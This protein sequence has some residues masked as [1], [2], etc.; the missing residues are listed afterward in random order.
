MP[1]KPISTDRQVNA[2]KPAATQYD[3]SISGDR[4]LC[5][6]VYTSGA[7][8]FQF[9]YTAR[10]GARRR[11]VMG[12]YPDLSLAA[13]RIKAAGLR[14]E[15]LEGG[16]PAGD[17][18]AEKERARTGETL[19]DL[20]QAY[21][22]AAARGLHGGRRR[23]KAQSSLDKEQGH[24]RRHISPRAGS[25]RLDEIRRNDIKMLMKA[26]V[27]ETK[28]APATLADIGGMVHA[29]LQYAVLEDRIG[30]NPAIGQTRPLAVESRDRLIS[31]E[32]L[33][34]ILRAAILSS[35]P[36]RALAKIPMDSGARMGPTVGL[37]LQFVIHSLARR[38]EVAG[39][40]REEINRSAMQWVI[41]AQRAKARHFHVVP[42]TASML[43]IID[44]AEALNPGSKYL[45]PSIG[46]SM[47]HLDPHTITRAFARIIERR[48]LPHGS[49]HDI[50]RSGATTLIGQYG[51]R[52]QI[53]GLLL[54]H[55]FREGAA[56]TSVYDRYSY[57]PE[58]RA[59]LE[60]WEGH[61]ARLLGQ[62]PPTRS[63]AAPE[64]LPIED[65]MGV[66]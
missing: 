45:F 6:R 47:E 52:R 26:L 37:A 12:N 27:Y 32:T 61:L 63:E 18:A 14:L 16:D 58:K 36:G 66:A 46:P 23:P 65:I 8:S 19:D 48:K 53:A 4:G 28:L 21:W 55:T 40:R 22:A 49:P 38:N 64:H 1:P 9:T 41:P 34:V 62:S 59:A 56:V 31:D 42:L 44:A 35:S 15:V 3:V 24:W 5:V 11:H 25:L 51:V 30:A 43:R 57:M 20:A 54:G 50:R 7:K 17:R 2:L 29:V 10:T 33:A 13:A 39:A 60:A